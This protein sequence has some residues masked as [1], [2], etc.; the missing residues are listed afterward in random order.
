MLLAQDSVPLVLE[1]VKMLV[2]DAKE[3]V[4]AL[5]QQLAAQVVVKVV[6]ALA[7][8]I[9]AFFALKVISVF[10]IVETTVCQPVLAVVVVAVAVIAVG[11][12]REH[13]V[14]VVD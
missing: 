2:K 10:T 6:Q 8:L 12:V 11:I 7:N 13:V 1:A 4:I 5:A 9:V 14:V 3:V